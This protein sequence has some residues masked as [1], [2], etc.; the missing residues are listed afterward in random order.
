MTQLFLVLALLYLQISGSNQSW[1]PTT[2]SATVQRSAVHE[3]LLPCYIL[4]LRV[5]CCFLTPCI[6]SVFLQPNSLSLSQYSDEMYSTTLRSF[7]CSLLLALLLPP[8]IAI[9]HMKLPPVHWVNKR[10]STVPLKVTN[11]CN[12]DI[13]P[14]IQ[15]QSG[16]GPDSSG[17]LLKP[18]TSNSQTVSADWNGRVW[19]RTN[20]SFNAE[21]IAS[22]TGSGPACTTGDCGGTVACPSTVSPP[23]GNLHP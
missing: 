5:L 1:E 12:E 2:G 19:A 3:W 4:L 17:F 15:T 10:D 23:C 21:G 8:T 11:L 16:T 6:Y 9:H 20:C 22:A 13:Y 14:G 18:G 7:E